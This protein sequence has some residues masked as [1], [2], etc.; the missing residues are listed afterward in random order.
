MRML[1]DAELSC[2]SGGAFV[3]PEYDPLADTNERNRELFLEWLERQRRQEG[4]QR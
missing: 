3:V 2:V 4:L 1:A